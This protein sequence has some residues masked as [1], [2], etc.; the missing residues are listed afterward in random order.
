MS[1]APRLTRREF[2][3]AAAVTGAGL[4]LAISFQGCRTA[5]PPAGDAPFAPNAFLRIRPDGSV[6]VVIGRSEMGQ[7]PTTALAMV[8]AEELDCEWGRVSFEQAPAHPAYHDA[9]HRAQLTG[10]SVS[11]RTSWRPMRE[12]GAV[13]RAMLVTAAAR[14]WEVDETTCR[15]EGGAVHHD[16]SGRT[17]EY[18]ELATRAAEIPI[19]DEVRL[20]DPS[21]FKLVGQPLPRLD[22]PDKVRGTAGFGLDA[23]LPGQ[24][25]ASVERCPVFGGRV[26]RVE[27]GAARGMPGVVDV[28]R[29]DSAVAVVA[30]Q[31]WQAQ[32]A[33][34]ALKITW[35]EGPNTA[36]DDAAIAAELTGLLAQGKAKVAR[37]V[38]AGGSSDQGAATTL[39]ARYDV[40]FL[41]HA[42]MEPM[43]CTAWVHDGQVEVW[44]PTQYQS[45]PFVVN[46]GGAVGVAARAADVGTARATVHTTYLGGG[47]GRRLENDYVGE[48]VAIARVVGRPV[49]VIWT[50]EDDLRH[51]FY[52]PR[53]AHA[54]SARLGRDG[55]PVSFHARVACPSIIRRW[56]P[57]WLPDFAANLGGALRK[58]VDIYATQGMDD[59]PYGIPNQLVEWCEAPARVPVGFWRSVG[60]SHNAFAAECF[61]DE[62]AAAAHR[63]PVD[64]RRDLLAD[65][66]RHR[67]V[68]DLVAEEA[69]W[70]APLP[71]G[72]ARGIALVNAFESIVAQ[73]AEI[74][75]TEARA[76]RVHRVTCAADCGIVVNPDIVAAQ[77]EGGVAFGLSA[78]LWGNVTVARG[79]ITQG[80]FDSYRMLRLPEMPEVDVHLVPS[81]EEPGGVGELGVPPIAPA[82]A[83]ALYALTGQRLRQLPLR[84]EDPATLRS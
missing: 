78:A 53:V 73:V 19:P 57:D 83:N 13:G 46:Q 41:A 26:A 60:Y 56:L 52:R 48:A 23:R 55:R 45:G 18:G 40:P 81:G 76:I 2:V 59:L 42:T 72:R 44:A 70:G 67:A 15:T 54:L 69:D 34:R 12:A 30:G 9:F 62:L 63:D 21:D 7:G 65:L 1:D 17:L 82:V 4:T 24:L 25:Y 80:N 29:L 38:A 16:P 35:D 11:I 58:G 8:V 32:A 61:I 79:R 66:P 22:T 27:D 3:Q 84:L 37:R 28:V 75:L 64:Y 20:K 77:L 74:S 71:D 5:P 50:R 49:Q 10:D 6:T 43:N 51:D 31:F 33:R 39:E 47:F 68:L 14:A 36:L